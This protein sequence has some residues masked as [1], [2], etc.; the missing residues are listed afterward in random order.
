MS[1]LSLMSLLGRGPP[2]R[3]AGPGE[4]RPSGNASSSFSP[5]VRFPGAFLD[6]L[7]WTT[8]VMLGASVLSRRGLICKIRPAHQSGPQSPRLAQGGVSGP[9]G[10]SGSPSNPLL[11]NVQRNAS[12]LLISYIS[13]KANTQ[14]TPQETGLASARFFQTRQGGEQAAKGSP[15]PSHAPSSA[16]PRADRSSSASGPGAVCAAGQG[17]PGGSGSQWPVRR[18]P[19]VGAAQGDPRGLGPPPLDHP[20]SGVEPGSVRPTHPSSPSWAR[21]PR[22]PSLELH[23]QHHPPCKGLPLPSLASRQQKSQD[24]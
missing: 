7:P 5:E 1:V 12:N 23:P 3:P 2:A 21:R 11:D 14:C 4:N 6:V 10:L 13:K 18:K 20:V 22:A 16:W 15:F 24:G 8:C 9:W 17:P 19:W